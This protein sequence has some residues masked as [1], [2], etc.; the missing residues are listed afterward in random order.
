VAEL[1]TDKAP[2]VCEAFL[3]KLP[4]GGQELCHAM[5]AGQELYFKG[6]LGPVPEENAVKPRAGDIAYAEAPCYENVLIYYGDA[7]FFPKYFTIFAR[8]T[9]NLDELMAVGKR[10][11]SKGIEKV[12]VKEL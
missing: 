4:I 10:V 3:K 8:I 11:W 5:T 1:L 12:Y 2:K 7:I 6:S 9:E